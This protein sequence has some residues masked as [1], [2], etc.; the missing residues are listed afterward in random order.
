MREHSE[1]HQ[2]G[3]LKFRQEVF[4]FSKNSRVKLC[5]IRTVCWRTSLPPPSEVRKSKRIE[6]RPYGGSLFT[7]FDTFKWRGSLEKERE[8]LGYTSQ[9]TL[10]LHSPVSRWT[11]SRTLMACTLTQ[12]LRL[13]T[14]RVFARSLHLKHT[15]T[16]KRRSTVLQTFCRHSKRSRIGEKRTLSLF[17]LASEQASVRARI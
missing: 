12:S 2:K 6:A 16:K 5:A 9:F 15:H 1:R 11:R 7:F 14:S 10:V 13:H 3:G 8:S 17:A 4:D